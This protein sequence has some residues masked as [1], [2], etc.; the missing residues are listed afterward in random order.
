MSRAGTNHW[1]TPPGVR[2]DCESMSPAQARRK[3]PVTAGGEYLLEVEELVAGGDALARLDGFPIFVSGIYPGDLARVQITEVK[4]GFGRG[5]SIELVR[6][7]PLR[8]AEPCPVAASCGGCDWTSLRLDR[9]LEAKL[10]ILRQSLRRVGKFELPAL[11]DIR[12][13]PSALN[14]RLRSR[15]HVDKTSMGFFEQGSHRVVPLPSECEVTGPEV[16]R[17]L[18]DLRDVAKS[19]SSI[20]T[21]ETEKSFVAE[22]ADQEMSTTVEVEVRQFSYHLSLTSFFQVNRHL[23]GSLID[24]VSALARSAIRRGTAWDLYAGVGFFTS[25]LATMFERV[26][27]VEGSQESARY[28]RINTATYENVSFKDMD[29]KSFFASSPGEVDF[30]FLDPPRMGL[31]VT[32]PERVSTTD[33]KKVCYLSCDPVTFS[34]DASRL[35]RHGWKLTSLDLFD[36]FPNTHHIET[37]S[38]FERA[39]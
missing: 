38:S 11:P 33:A 5:V 27:A 12:I 39:R 37:L 18:A 26:I 29:V 6:A 35:V 19:A 34:R 17:H 10:H 23:L 21:F 28:G 3:P 16:I 31:D 8:R 1:Q 24:T 20:R 9:Q 15:L 4:A 36:L 7:S 14:Y 25:P 2:V 30:I 32:M 22:N 13:H